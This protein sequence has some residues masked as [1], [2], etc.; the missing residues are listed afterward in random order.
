MEETKQDVVTYKF[1]ELIVQQ[2]KIS[3]TL[4]DFFEITNFDPNQFFDSFFWCALNSLGDDK[5]FEVSDDV[6]ETIGYKGTMTRMDSTRNNMFNF[7]KKHFIEN[8]DYMFV[9]ESKCAKS[10][11]GGHNKPCQ[12]LLYRYS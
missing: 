8:I 10:G 11:S 3:L 2:N 6:I 4:C 5:W 12:V 9:H 1:H 7:I